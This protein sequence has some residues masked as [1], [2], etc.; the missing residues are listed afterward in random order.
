MFDAAHQKT[1]VQVGRN[2][3]LYNASDSVTRVVSTPYTASYELCCSLWQSHAKRLAADALKVHRASVST[4][5]AAERGSPWTALVTIEL[6][7]CSSWTAQQQHT[8]TRLEFGRRD[9]DGGPVLGRRRT[10]KL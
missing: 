9:C 7:D 8:T 1:T 2:S 4:S 6:A 10:G 3:I 5:T